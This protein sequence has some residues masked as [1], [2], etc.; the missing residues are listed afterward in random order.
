[1]PPAFPLDIRPT[2]LWMLGI[3]L[4][5]FSYGAF[6]L[7]GAAFQRTSNREAGKSPS[8]NST[9]P[10]HYWRDS[11][12]PAPLSVALTN[13]ITIVYYGSLPPPSSVFEPSHPPYNVLGPYSQDSS[14]MNIMR[15]A[16]SCVHS[17]TPGFRPVKLERLNTF[18][19]PCIKSA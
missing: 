1:M 5:P 4:L 8:P 9:S 12:C 10:F 13:G 16:S 11:V 3:L 17:I 2:V 7:Y 18:H 19:L 6:T 15:I 14:P